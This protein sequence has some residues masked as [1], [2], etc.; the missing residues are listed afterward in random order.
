MTNGRDVR[1][2]VTPLGQEFW[3]ALQIGDALALA[4]RLLRPEAA[5]EIAAN[6]GVFAVAGELADVVDLVDGRT[7]A[8]QLGTRLAADPARV[9]H[10]VVKR[11]ADHGIAADNLTNLLVSELSLP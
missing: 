4:R 9:K 7:Q 3:E 6:A 1:V 11:R 10:P 5:I 8:D 2:C